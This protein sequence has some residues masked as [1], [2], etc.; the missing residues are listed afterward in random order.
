[1]K[2]L[3]FLIILLLFL[4]WYIEKQSLFIDQLTQFLETTK[5]VPIDYSKINGIS[6]INWINLDRS[7]DRQKNMESLLNNVNVP[8][9][10][11]SAIDGK[12]EALDNYRNDDKFTN[13]E[14]ACTLSHIKAINSL[15]GSHGEYFMVCEDDI[16]FDNL[17]YFNES[18]DDII[19]SSPK[20]DIL[21]V[22]NNHEF[23]LEHYQKWKPGI[24]GAVAYII[25]KD[26]INKFINEVAEYQ[27]GIYKL[28]KPIEVADI[29][30]YKYLNTIV[31]K[32]CFIC[33]QFDNSTIHNNHLSGH[34]KNHFRQLNI[35]MKKTQPKIKYECFWE[36]FETEDDFRSIFEYL[37]NHISRPITVISVFGTVPSNIDNSRLIIMYSGESYYKKLDYPCI[38]LVMTPDSGKNI[39]QVPFFSIHA[40]RRN[41]WPILRVPRIRNKKNKFCAFVSSNGHGDKHIRNRFMEQLSNK[42]SKVDSCGKYRNN[43]GYEAPRE[44]KDYM[45]F[46]NNYRFSICFENKNQLNYVT[47]KLF[48][49]WLGGCIPIYWG[50]K[51]VFDWFNPKAFLYLESDTPEA[52]D[53]LINTIELLDNNS[54]LYEQVHS[55]PLLVGPI[56]ECM[57]CEY[58]KEK[59]HEINNELLKH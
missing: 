54:E 32:Y 27:N 49:S 30:I 14:I 36:G 48:Y 37:F 2:L 1:M 7:P 13:Y 47:E 19:K 15:K 4:I 17:K 55:D 28:Y 35:I 10:R 25:T 42:Y 44:H 23:E 38:N 59:I 34:E 9:N 26:G 57:D 5:N 18:L 50:S 39:I 58:W 53:K 21:M 45:K 24:F 40:Y 16:T 6:S 29:F 8:N 22:Y 31:Y 20:F 51:Q 52:F 56:P 33:T 11:I 12:K 43:I 41:A 3:L 46:L